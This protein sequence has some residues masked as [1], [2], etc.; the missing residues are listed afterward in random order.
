V[1]KPSTAA[2]HGQRAK[3]DRTRN[4]DHTRGWRA[5]D[6]YNLLKAVVSYTRK[7]KN[8]PAGAAELTVGVIGDNLLNDDIRNSVPFK[9]DEVLLPG[10]TVRVFAKA[11]F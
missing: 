10:R 9:K 2:D 8:A 3:S 11:T 7:L 6:G 1:R 5:A 4:R